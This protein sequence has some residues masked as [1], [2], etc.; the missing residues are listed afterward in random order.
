VML[1]VRSWPRDDVD[2]EVRRILD[3]FEI[4]TA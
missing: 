2:R 4:V 1:A 3:S